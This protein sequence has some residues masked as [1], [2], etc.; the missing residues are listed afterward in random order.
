MPITNGD[1]FRRLKTLC[2]GATQREA[3]AKLG[4]SVQY[5]RDILHKRRPLSDQM[6]K[7]V[8][9]KRVVTVTLEERLSRAGSDGGGTATPPA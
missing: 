7:K 1:A 5:L 4:I 3:A 8:G 9:L 2:R 6:L